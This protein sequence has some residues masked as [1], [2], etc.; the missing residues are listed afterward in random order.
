MPKKGFDSSVNPR[1]FREL[2]NRLQET[3]KRL[4]AAEEANAN[5]KKLLKGKEPAAEKKVAD[6]L[7]EKVVIEEKV[8]NLQQEKEVAEKEAADLQKEKE[9]LQKQ[10][11]ELQKEQKESKQ[12]LT[13][14][15]KEKEAAEKKAAELLKDQAEAKKALIDL[16]K[17]IDNL[18][19]QQPVKAVSNVY[20]QRGEEVADSTLLSGK[21]QDDF[22]DQMAAA[23]E[24]LDKAQ[25]IARKDRGMRSLFGIDLR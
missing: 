5:M 3:E 19:K 13:D 17:E 12:A 22:R 6:S 2:N 9:K 4:A 16:Q 24:A 25:Q 10:V 18:Q 11:E 14:L 21:E 20:G 7:K 8:A 15:Q 23:Y 1:E